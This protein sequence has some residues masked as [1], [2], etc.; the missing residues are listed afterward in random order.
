MRRIRVEQAE[1]KGPRHQPDTPAAA[2]FF[3]DAPKMHLLFLVCFTQTFYI[4]TYFTK[5][6][7]LHQCIQRQKWAGAK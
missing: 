7:V 5:Q 3:Y 6:I 4:K 2:S 1:G